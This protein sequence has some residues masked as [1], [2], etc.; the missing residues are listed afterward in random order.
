[1]KNNTRN[2]IAVSY[3]VFSFNLFPI[4]DDRKPVGFVC[5]YWDVDDIA[6]SAEQ[7]D[8]IY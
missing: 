4:Y 8:A 3:F 7:S 2:S 5:H 6:W 1:M